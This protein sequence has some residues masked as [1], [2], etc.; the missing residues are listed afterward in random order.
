MLRLPKNQSNNKSSSSRSNDSQATNVPRVPQLAALRRP[1]NLSAPVVSKEPSF[2]EKLLKWAQSVTVDYKNVNIKNFS[3]SWSNGLAFCAILH[4]YFPNKIDF[5]KLNAENRK[6]NF[7]K[8]FNLAKELG[9]EP[10][11][12]TEDMLTMGDRPDEKCIF[13]SLRSFYE[14]FVR[15]RKIPQI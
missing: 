8:A 6:E 14:F 3:S 13:T 5:S 7:D 4:H 15:I 1:T 12:D 11:L 10:C 9:F 2:K